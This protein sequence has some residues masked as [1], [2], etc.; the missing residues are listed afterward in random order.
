M[1]RR[2]ATL[3]EALLATALLAVAGGAL[4]L[5]LA[6]ASTA[7]QRMILAA[8]ARRLLQQEL[9]QIRSGR[10]IP[11]SGVNGPFTVA[12]STSA[13]SQPN[14]VG[15]TPVWTPTC[16]GATPCSNA[17]A[18]SGVVTLTNVAITIT[19]TADGSVVARGTTTTPP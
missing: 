11:A 6:E 1:R 13:S 17:I 3:A 9:E 18:L 14:V 10:G 12:L 15:G 2:G 4:T 8:Q 19:Y 5:A 16:Y 7:G